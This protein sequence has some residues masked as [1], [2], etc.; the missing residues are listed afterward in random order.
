[1]QIEKRESVLQF[2]LPGKLFRAAMAYNVA[3]L[4]LEEFLGDPDSSIKSYDQYA[5]EK[6]P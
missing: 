5:V 2:D 3:G 6:E 4:A 1:M